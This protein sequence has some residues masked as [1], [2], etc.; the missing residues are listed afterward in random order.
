MAQTFEELMLPHY[1]TYL[2]IATKMCYGDRHKAEDMVQEALL[3]AFIHFPEYDGSYK[4]TTWFHKILHNTIMD[5]NR[6]EERAKS[7]YYDYFVWKG[8]R[9]PFYS[10][11][12]SEEEDL[13]QECLTKIPEIIENLPP[14]DKT[15][16]RMYMAGDDQTK[17][18]K[19]IGVS[20]G[21]AQQRIRRICQ[22]LHEDLVNKTC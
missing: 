3:K 20:R 12:L 5:T 1:S 18:G 2:D 6:I 19:A 7:R 10:M 14:T 22:R 8:L 9:D 13:I 16:I 17:I 15:I 21:A 11:D 4:I